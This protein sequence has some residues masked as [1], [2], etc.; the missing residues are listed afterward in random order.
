MESKHQEVTFA[1]I[2]PNVI[3]K[4][5]AGEI[6]SFLQKEHFCIVGLKLLLVSKTL[7]EAFYAE[8]K[9]RV[10]FKELV[11]FIT[12]SPVI[13]LALQR[14]NAVLK[15]REIMGDTDPKQAHSDSLRFKYGDSIGENAI[16]GS[17]SLKSAT[18]ELDLFFAK[19]D[20][21]I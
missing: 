13:I 11:S 6:I 2:K 21:F 8:H 15:L 14:E 3:K 17:D 5:Q 12:A 9:E 1:L 4:Q 7:C 18:R 10:F 16:H 20:L 19:D